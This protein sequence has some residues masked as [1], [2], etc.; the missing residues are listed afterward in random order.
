MRDL[1]RNDF[2]GNSL[3]VLSVSQDVK[4]SSWRALHLGQPGLGMEKEYLDQ[5]CQHMAYTAM[6]RQDHHVKW[7][8]ITFCCPQKSSRRLTTSL[9]VMV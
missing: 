5:V 2:D 7:Q 4:N 3:L 8:C 6:G 1:Q 9:G